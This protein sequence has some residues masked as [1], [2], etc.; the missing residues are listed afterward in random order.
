MKADLLCSPDDFILQDPKTHKIADFFSFY[1]LP[2]SV[3][4]NDKHKSLNAAYM[5]YYAIDIPEKE[6]S[7]SYDTARYTKQRLTE[8]MRDALVLAKQVCVYS[9]K[10]G[11]NST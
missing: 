4:G 2:S 11:A 7:D 6:A 5:F 8:L 9:V 3:I 1:T 10:F